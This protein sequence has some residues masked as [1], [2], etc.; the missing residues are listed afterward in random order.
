VLTQ[1]G[2]DLGDTKLSQNIQKPSH[3]IRLGT[4]G[5]KESKKPEAYYIIWNAS[6]GKAGWSTGNLVI[7]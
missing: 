2:W 3:P 1:A 7:M 5:H 6:L 4:K